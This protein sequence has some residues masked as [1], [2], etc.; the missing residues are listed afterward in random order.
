MSPRGRKGKYLLMPRYWC[1]DICFQVWS[2][3]RQTSRVHL[4]HL[5]WFREY[6]GSSPNPWAFSLLLLRRALGLVKGNLL[7]WGKSW[8]CDDKQLR[9]WG[10]WMSPLETGCCLVAALYEGH[11]ERGHLQDSGGHGVR[12][13]K[14]TPEH[15]I[16]EL[17]RTRLPV[18]WG[19]VVGEVVKRR[20]SPHLGPLWVAESE[21]VGGS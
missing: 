9:D 15:Q 6:Y 14:W 2:V 21:P 16:K 5:T 13:W 19:D 20:A 12:F 17:E 1:H 7:C 10:K 3:L 8:G 11:G 4:G 18:F